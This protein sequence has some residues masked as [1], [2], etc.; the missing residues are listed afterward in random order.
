MQINSFS[1]LTSLKLLLINDKINPANEKIIATN[2]PKIFSAIN[3]LTNASW[4]KLSSNLEVK[5]N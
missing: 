5:I 4:L 3:P 1:F 2:L